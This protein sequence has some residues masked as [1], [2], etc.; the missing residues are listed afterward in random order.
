MHRS[1]LLIITLLACA[2][3]RH[4]TGD[5]AASTVNAETTPGSEIA[6]NGTAASEKG[7]VEL[8]KTPVAQP[9]AKRNLL[10]LP[11]EYTE[12]VTLYSEARRALKAGDKDSA[13]ELLDQA[14][15]LRPNYP[16]AVRD[17]LALCRTEGKHEEALLVVSQALEK[18]PRNI[19]FGYEK[20]LTQFEMGK[21][22]D[23]LTTLADILDPEKPFPAARLLQMRALT[24]LGDTEA[25]LA[26]LEAA[27]AAGFTDT[28]L[29]AKEPLL[30]SIAGDPRFQNA[31]DSME[32]TKGRRPSEQEFPVLGDF[33]VGSV[34]AA[35]LVSQIQSNRASGAGWTFDFDLKDL[36]QTRARS[37][38]YRGKPLIM[39]AWG[40]WSVSSWKILPHLVKLKEL[41]KEDQLEVLL[42]GWE[43]RV[44]YDYG[45]S[46]AKSMLRDRKINLRSAA[47]VKESFNK[48]Y[49]QGCPSL[50]FVSPEGKVETYSLGY[51]PFEDL[52]TVTNA[53]LGKNE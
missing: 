19:T 5:S 30:Q 23:A 34:P 51:M 20:A 35:K 17:K 28:A 36:D 43:N 14:L 45:A 49:V 21:T 12:A 11:P 15:A 50:F 25:T 6:P 7:P 42:L 44:D 40:T 9:T 38:D 29:I 3:T 53:F 48:I 13:N 47:L 24:T 52:K 27:A 39:C 31:L 4:E 10:R 41:Y 1:A 37:R 2:C 33:G 22:N 8:A 16:L 18:S 26:A 32:R 46:M